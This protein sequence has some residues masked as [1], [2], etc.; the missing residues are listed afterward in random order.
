MSKDRGSTLLA[1]YLAVAVMLVYGSA[2]MIRSFTEQRAATGYRDLAEAFQAAESGLDDGIR[3]LRADYNNTASVASTI[4]NRGSYQVEITQD[5]TIRTLRSTGT[6]SN[7]AGITRRLEAKVQRSIPQNFYDQAIYAAGNV[8]LK[9]D[10]YSIVGNVLSGSSTAVANAG[11]V[12]GDVVNDPSAAPL[13]R[14][15]FQQLYDLAVSQGNVYDAQRLHD[16][17]HGEDAFP[18][19]F[20]YAPPT[21]PDDPSTCAPNINYITADL[22]LNGNIGTIGGFFV[23][24][25]NVLTDP[26]AVEDTTIN[27]NGQIEGLIYT[28]GDFVINGGGAGLNIDGGVWA[29][30]VARLNGSATTEHHAA[31]MGAVE[32]LGI[33]ADLQLIQWRE[34]APTGC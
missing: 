22:V 34:C 25:G 8:V 33:N 30:D 32:H 21:D 11:N 5:G 26:E 9:G 18:A 31:Y 7:N 4:G 14:L 10:A 15:D 27:G 20:C 12:E 28:T 16:I 24:V 13:P 6:T 29:G 1:C 3:Q 23:V 17:Q 2:L 19:A